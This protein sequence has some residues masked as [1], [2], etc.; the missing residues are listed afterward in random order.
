VDIDAS[1]AFLVSVG[2][3]YLVL[4]HHVPTGKIHAHYNSAKSFFRCCCFAPGSIRQVACVSST[5]MKQEP[6]LTLFHYQSTANLN[7][8]SKGSIKFT[9][10]VSAIIWPS[11]GQIICGDEKGKLIEVPVQIGKFTEISRTIE[12]HRGAINSMTMSFDR[13]FFATAS[14]DTTASTWDLKLNKL[15]TFP[16][17]F[18]VSCCAISPKAPHIV[19]ASS[20]DKRTVATTNFGSTDFTINFFHLVFQEEFASIKVHKSMIN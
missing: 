3:D 7:L 16:H 17:A 2:A 18:L 20:A 11:D 1:S 15:E 9:D 4:I 19:L 13:R 12:A 8:K 14:A 6:I 10:A 5:Q